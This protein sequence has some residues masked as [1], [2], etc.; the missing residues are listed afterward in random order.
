MTHDQHKFLA[1]CARRVRE[2]NKVPAAFSKA[3]R[4]ALKKLKV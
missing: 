4:E 1:E 2:Q 3:Q